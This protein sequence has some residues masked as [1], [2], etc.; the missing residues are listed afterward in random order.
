[1]EAKA[2]I[3]TTLWAVYFGWLIVVGLAAGPALGQIPPGAV[4]FWHLDETNSGTYTDII[5]N[6]DG[7]CAGVCPAPWLNGA[8]DANG[9][10]VFNGSSTAILI[11]GSSV[12]DWAAGD[13]FSIEAW[14]NRRNSGF[15]G[16][17]VI[18]GRADA[19]GP[20]LWSLG[21]NVNG[22][23][24]FRLTSTD[25][26]SV[27]LISTKLLSLNRWHHIAA[28]KLGNTVKIYVDGQEAGTGF[29]FFT[30][31]FA[32]SSADISIGRFEL[33]GGQQY[34]SGAIDE[35]AIYDQPLSLKQIRGHYF[36]ARGYDRTVDDPVRIMP[37]GDS[38]TADSA[39]EPDRTQG[40]WFTGY[41]R[42]LWDD[43]TANGFRVDF[44]G[45]EPFGDFANPAFDYDNAGFPGI[46]AMSLLSELLNNGYNPALIDG[47]IFNP[48]DYDFLGEI[49]P[50]YNQQRTSTFGISY[51]SE[52]PTDV[53][54]LH[55]GTNGLTNSTIAENLNAIGQILDHI[56]T[57][58]E[59]I[60]VVL[61][62]IVNH[63]DGGHQPTS[64]Y[65][66]QIEALAQQ[67]IANGDKIIVVDHE[68]ALIYPDDMFNTVHPNMN[69][70]DK[71]AFVWFEAL[72]IFLPIA[73]TMTASVT[74][75]GAIQPS[76]TE[77]VEQ[78]ASVN[79]II[80]PGPSAFIEDVVVDGL[81]VGT[82]SEYLF[83]DISEDHSIE[84]R[85]ASNSESSVGGG[86]GGGGGGCFIGTVF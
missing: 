47:I 20:M 7:S 27:V 26:Q 82:P 25:N 56:D 43:L 60:T 72:D 73:H 48:I 62:R 12:F 66:I 55:I 41:R 15:L 74:G 23:V 52:Y 53:I 59:K 35:V 50:T 49:Y 86:G 67:R 65:N 33:G 83:K 71:M 54:L 78:G 34:Y 10:Q 42:P 8:V 69:G 77:M 51:L 80:N 37:L 3:K 24:V 17:E 19:T 63:Q 46:T 22:A 9:A 5:A 29:Q 84:V 6:H 45:G 44:V 39:V 1:M 75:S 79:Y 16:S 28:V 64:D 18:V 4:A 40:D 11:P 31:S 70:Y 32:S 14:V 36:L 2:T 13:S 61:A 68:S 30:G 57:I 85:F 21:T 81:S 38:I 76:G 58:D